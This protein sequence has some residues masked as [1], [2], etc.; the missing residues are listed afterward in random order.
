MNHNIVCIHSAAACSHEP[1]GAVAGGRDGGVGNIYDGALAIA[2]N[3]ICVRAVGCNGNLTQGEY[4]AALS[5]DCGVFTVEVCFVSL[6]AAR[7]GDGDIAIEG[8]FCVC[9]NGMT[10][11]GIVCIAVSGGWCRAIDGGVIRRSLCRLGCGA[12]GKPPVSQQQKRCDER[13]SFC[14][15]FHASA[16]LLGISITDS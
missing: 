14:V 6:G 10:A 4:R 8:I 7:L 12:A 5:K 15:E 3:G 16:L 13:E 1:A 11:V 2:E 9:K